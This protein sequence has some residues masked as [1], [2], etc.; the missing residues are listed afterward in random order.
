M[1][2][3]PAVHVVFDRYLVNSM[4]SQTREKRRYDVSR[5]TSVHIQG[6]IFQIGI[7]LLSMAASKQNS[8]S[9]IPYI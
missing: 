9:F 7:V 5:V 1:L 6:E 4:K 8:Q 2:F 3:C